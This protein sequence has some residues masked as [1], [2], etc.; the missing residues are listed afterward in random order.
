MAAKAMLLAA[1]SP[2]DGVLYLLE[3]AEILERSVLAARPL[4][5]LLDTMC[6][7]T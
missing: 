6:H 7:D 3:H 2:Q 1:A 4:P 5:L